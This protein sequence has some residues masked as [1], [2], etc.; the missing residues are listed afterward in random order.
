MPRLSLDIT[1]ALPGA[2]PELQQLRDSIELNNRKLEAFLIANTIS[3]G[4]IAAFPLGVP[5]TGWLLLDGGSFSAA[6]Y[7]DLATYLGGTTLPDLRGRTLFGLDA[8]QTEFD[9][10][11]EV[12][13]A[14][15]GIGAHS[16]GHDHPVTVNT[17]FSGT[18]GNNNDTSDNGLH[19]HGIDTDF[20]N[21]IAVTV[22]SGA[23][24]IPDTADV[25]SGQDISYSDI[26]DDGTHHHAMN[27]HTHNIDHDHTGFSDADATSAGTAAGN[28][29]PYRVVN[30]AIKT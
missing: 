13:G 11:G 20:G 5:S 29:P 28:L 12:G 16:H 27:N 23:H 8:T 1:P 22:V 3:T 18:G 10:I 6:T 30:W 2:I 9:L 24:R 26:D 21:R 7:P 25:P 15:N 17:H 4:T 19:A 14:K